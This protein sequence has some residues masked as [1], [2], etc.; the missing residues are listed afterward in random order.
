MNAK[1]LMT[2]ITVVGLSFALAANA[3]AED[4]E[5]SPSLVKD[6]V[7]AV[8]QMQQ[9]Y[10]LIN[11]L[12]Q[13]LS[14]PGP[15]ADQLAGELLGSL[16]QIERHPEVNKYIKAVVDQKKDRLAAQ[17]LLRVVRVQ[18]SAGDWGAHS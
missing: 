9:I 18:L 13:K 5:Q 6:L 11:K 10:G 4:P 12:D 14:K 16:D 7:T 3:L 17:L 8:G 1:N 2:T 15:E